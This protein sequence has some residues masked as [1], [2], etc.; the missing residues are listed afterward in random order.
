MGISAK[1]RQYMRQVLEL[2]ALAHG[3][4]SPNPMVGAL[5]VRNDE[6]LG[7]GYHKQSGQ[8]HAEIE[9]LRNAKA[10]GFDTKGATLYCNMEPCNHEG[11]TPPCTEALIK[12]GISRVVAAMIDPN[13]LV[14][15]SGLRRLRAAGIEV[16]CGVMEGEARRLNEAFITYHQ[17]KRPFIIAKW[18]MTLDGRT[19]AESGD[20]RWIS[21]D[22]SRRYAHEIRASV[23]AVAVG[24]GTVFF[25]NPRLTVRLD[26]FKRTQ[27]K[28]VI[29][30][31]YLR[32]PVGARCLDAAGGPALLICTE[33]AP[34][35]RIE[36]LRKAGH[37]ILV[38]PGK[39]RIINVPAAMRLLADTG[40]QSVLV[41]G[42]RQL[43]TSLLKEKLVD[44]LVV[45]IGP[46]M[47]G[48]SSPTS[49]LIDLGISNMKSAIQLK[50]TAFKTFGNNAC[51]E[52]YINLPPMPGNSH[53]F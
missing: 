13:P 51:I 8:P 40:I 7:E 3:Y 31:G 25:D 9:A 44:K 42:G 10:N 35:D 14:C 43:H 47:V 28:R 26:S 6:I 45:F 37:T 36:I 16:D 22:D 23:D 12:S 50:N 49:P 29:F 46:Q 11:K 21:N 39:G 53:H 2:A 38:V 41:E 32:T 4:T 30:D 17:L 15:G 27:P 19:S 52:G 1:D 34:N 48:G 24:I 18:A 20:S 5:I 33:S